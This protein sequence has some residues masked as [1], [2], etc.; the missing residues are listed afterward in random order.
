MI[1][2]LPRLGTVVRLGA[3]LALAALPFSVALVNIGVGL[4]VLAAL[5]SQEF[6]VW[7]GTRLRHHPVALI[8][9]LMLLMLLAG[10][11]YTDAPASDVRMY[12]IHY[13]KLLVLPLL[14]P[15]LAEERQRVQA[16]QLFCMA[17]AVN[18][19]CSWGDFLGW[20]H[21]SL[22][23]YDGPPGDNVFRTHITQ[24]YLFA[25]QV[26]LALVLA[27]AARST[28]ARWAW[29]ALAALAALDIAIVMIGRTGKA[30]L[31]VLLVWFAFECLPERLKRFRLAI[32]ATV[33]VA[34]VALVWVES[35]HPGSRIGSLTAEVQQTE[36]T[37][38]ATST[39]LRVS[40]YRKGLH[41]L[42]ERPW[43]GF[44]TGAVPI[45]MARLAAQ[46]QGDNDRTA[47]I[48]M[49]CEFLMWGVQFGLPGVAALVG[50][51]LAIW[52]RS[53]ALPPTSG[54]ML[55]GVLLVF[56]SGSLVNS[57]LWD[58]TEGFATLITMGILLAP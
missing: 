42:R 57:F 3:C 51:C 36:A 13:R 54:R 21:F 58:F 38:S 20:S 8:A 14:L 40:F 22:P 50:L 46:A 15:F 44:G 4:A 34:A 35:H 10:I 18:V 28:A 1:E 19:A 5:L 39:G 49:H 12:L 26:A 6:W 25:L 48:N 37:G 32:V 30:V 47:T 55:R 23:A 29:S 52:W 33:V 45:E 11:S 16:M 7:V 53:L 56:V 9:C 27:R 41:L 43:T 24:G 17:L 31:P 2:R